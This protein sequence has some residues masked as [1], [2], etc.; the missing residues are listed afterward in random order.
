M[1]TYPAGGLEGQQGFTARQIPGMDCRR[2]SN[3]GPARLRMTLCIN[4][5]CG[6]DF[7]TKEESWRTQRKTESAGEIF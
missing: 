3:L 7:G 4:P 2:T 6:V 1:D 5:I